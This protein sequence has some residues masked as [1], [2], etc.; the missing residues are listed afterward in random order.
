MLDTNQ[1]NQ[2]T[3]VAQDVKA[4]LQMN[5][6][7]IAFGAALAGREIRNFNLWCAGV[8]EFVI[9]HGGAGLILK[10]LFWNPGAEINAETQRREG[11]KAAPAVARTA[12]APRS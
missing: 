9:R 8:A 4:Q 11:A 7:A 5:W 2:V 3:A 6:T 1:I 12:D 10:K